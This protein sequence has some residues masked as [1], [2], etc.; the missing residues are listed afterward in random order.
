MFDFSQDPENQAPPSFRGA[1][2]GAGRPGDWKIIMD[3]VPS[4]FPPLSP[5][6]PQ[7]SHQAVLA[8]LARDPADEHFPLLIYEDE[9]F[10]DFTFS[11]R[12]KTVGGQ[13]ERMAGIAFRIQDETNYYVLRASSLGNTLRFYKVVD[14]VRGAVIGPDLKNSLRPVA[15]VGGHVPG[16][17]NSL[18]V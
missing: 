7:V 14:G 1:V 18:L 10:D 12:F 15:R 2:T 17:R 11:T 8:Q 4:A 6:A 13:V 5:Q 16:Q 3:E 9:I